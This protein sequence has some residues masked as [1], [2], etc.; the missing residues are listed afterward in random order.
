MNQRLKYTIY[1]MPGY[2]GLKIEYRD[3]L[4]ATNAGYLDPADEPQYIAINRNLPCCEQAFTIG[5]EICHFLKHHNVSRRNFNSRLLNSQWKS[6]RAKTYVR[7][8]RYFTNKLLPIEFEADMY[9]VSL[10][11]ELGAVDDLKDYLQ[12]HPEK[13]WLALYVVTHRLVRLPFQLVKKGITKLLPN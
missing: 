11:F 9:A 2:F 1:D 3:D 10:L 7:Y 13:T 8:L 5:H 6:R 12:L 4:P